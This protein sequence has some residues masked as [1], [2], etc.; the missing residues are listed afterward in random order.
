MRCISSSSRVSLSTSQIWH[1]GWGYNWTINCRIIVGGRILTKGP[2]SSFGGVHRGS[3]S[4]EVHMEEER[5]EVKVQE[6]EVEEGRDTRKRTRGGKRRE[7]TITQAHDTWMGWRAPT[8]E[9]MWYH[10][11]CA[12]W[13]RKGDGWGVLFTLSVGC[14]RLLSAV[15]E[16]TTTHLKKKKIFLMSS[17]SFCPNSTMKNWKKKCHLWYCW[18]GIG[19]ARSSPDS[20]WRRL[21]IVTAVR[22]S[23][24]SLIGAFLPDLFS[25]RYQ[26]FLISQIFPSG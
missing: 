7:Q 1:E 2:D 15:N 23:D 12:L 10:T 26:C 3:C 25:V 9:P 6:D 11:S 17:T 24:R 5:V 8:L 13:T 20:R 18:K 16:P 22:K 4:D 19:S 21:I 14:S